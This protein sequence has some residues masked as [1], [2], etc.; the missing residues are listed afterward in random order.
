V[1]NILIVDD[2][3]FMR[4]TLQFIVERAGHTVA[5]TAK[6]GQEAINLCQELRPDIVTLDILMGGID[7]IMALKAIKQVS[8][9]IKV[10]MVTAIGHEV[11]RNEAAAFGA[12]GY[13]RKPFKE[14]EIVNEIKNALADEYRA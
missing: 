4:G 3:A 8:P 6:D 9:Q 11:K 13:I 2:S 5:G 12:S 1:A 14:T 10:I 7:G